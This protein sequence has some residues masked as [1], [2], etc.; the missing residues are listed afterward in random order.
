MSLDVICRGCK[1]NDSLYTDS[2]GT[3]CSRCGPGVPMMSGVFFATGTMRLYKDGEP[4]GEEYRCHDTSIWIEDEPCPNT[5][6]PQ[7]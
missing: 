7:R 1:R 5:E 2:H 6:S 4:V 3:F